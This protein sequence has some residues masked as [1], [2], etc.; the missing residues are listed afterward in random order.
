MH[1]IGS[2]HGRTRGVAIV[3]AAKLLLVLAFLVLFRVLQVKFDTGLAV[4]V[5]L[6]LIVAAALVTYALRKGFL[7]GKRE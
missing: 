3:L 5:L 4:L 7:G 1:S 6:H 2:A